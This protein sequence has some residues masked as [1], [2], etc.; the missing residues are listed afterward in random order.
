MGPVAGLPT[1][2]QGLQGAGVG[3]CVGGGGAGGRGT[4]HLPCCAVV[5]GAVPGA[6]TRGVRGETVVG[7]RVSEGCPDYVAPVDD[8]IGVEPA[9]THTPACTATTA[10]TACTR[11]ACSV[12][13]IKRTAH[14]LQGRSPQHP[15]RAA[16]TAPAVLDIQHVVR[17]PHAAS[18]K[19]RTHHSQCSDFVQTTAYSMQ[20]TP[21]GIQHDA[22]ILHAAHN[23]QNLSAYPGRGLGLDA[24]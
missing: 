20:C 19:D 6:R 9:R 8:G 21:R 23:M 24:T 16:H 4:H 1:L 11:T 14:A 22:H 2:R 12:H 15:A 17:P 3:V 7:A 5:Q 13:A 18:S 10:G